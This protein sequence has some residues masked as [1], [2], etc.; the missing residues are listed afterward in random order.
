[1]C[2]LH[3]T[4]TSSVPCNHPIP[5]IKVHF[6]SEEQ[7]RTILHL[8]TQQ[9]LSLCVFRV[10]VAGFSDKNKFLLLFSSACPEE[11]IQLKES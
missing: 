9:N 6:C 11:P 5:L 7:L 2:K 1:M 3:F 10:I 4:V 8:H